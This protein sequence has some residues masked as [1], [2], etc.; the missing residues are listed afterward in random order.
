MT[1][2]HGRL[3]NSRFV[4]TESVQQGLDWPEGCIGGL[5]FQINLV[6]RVQRNCYEGQG[7]LD[8]KKVLYMAVS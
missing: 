8:W 2:P 7:R 4:H 6:Q 5:N 3:R 1:W